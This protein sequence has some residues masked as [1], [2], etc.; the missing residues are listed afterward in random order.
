MDAKIIEKHFTPDGNLPGLDHKA[1]IRTRKALNMIQIIR[2]TE[3]AFGGS[4]K[5]P[6]LS[7]TNII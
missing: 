7:E 4:N 6:T 1:F 5:K 2:N 3:K